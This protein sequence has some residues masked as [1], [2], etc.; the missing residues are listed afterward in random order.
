MKRK[1]FLLTLIIYSLVVSSCN[2]Q[3][4]DSPEP[5]E[6]TFNYARTNYVLKSGHTEEELE[7]A[8]WVNTNID[9]MIEAIE[10]PSIKDDFYTHVNY[11][12]ITNKSKGLFNKSSDQVISNLLYLFDP[13]E[14]DYSDRET[15]LYLYENIN[16][17]SK[18]DINNYLTSL[19]VDS[20]LLSKEAITLPSMPIKLLDGGSIDY[21]SFNYG[22]F[23]SL[24]LLGFYSF[25]ADYY[26]DYM[27]FK[28]AAIS[29]YTTLLT[30]MG[31]AQ[32]EIPQM[33]T[34]LLTDVG[35]YAYQVF[36][37]FHNAGSFTQK[38]VDSLQ[39]GLKLPLV[40]YGYALT[41]NIKCY[42][43]VPSAMSN[44]KYYINNLE[45]YI[46]MCIAFDYRFLLGKDNYN[47]ISAAIRS[48]QVFQDDFTFDEDDSEEEIA[49]KLVKGLVP[50]ILDKG[51]IQE[52]DDLELREQ[53]SNLID[54]VIAGYKTYVNQI[55]W[56]NDAG[57]NHFI[58]KLDNIR[59]F[60][61]YSD[62]VKAYPDFDYDYSSPTTKLEVMNDYFKYQMD[63]EIQ[64]LV[65]TEVSS[66]CYTV[67]AFYSP[68][69][70]SFTILF[71]LLACRDW[72]STSKE[73]LFARLSFVIGHEISHAFDPLRITY[74]KN[75]Q[76]KRTWGDQEIRERY[77]SRITKMVDFYNKI[78]VLNNVTAD[79][80][81]QKGEIFADFGAMSVMLNM[82]KSIENFNYDKFFKE[83]AQTWLNYID[84]DDLDYY[85]G[86]SHPLYFLRVNAVV[87]Q[88]EE[89]QNTYDIKLGDGMYV[90]A[91]ERVAPYNQ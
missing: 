58:S 6:D 20:F 51:Y 32:E 63:L 28:E 19:D 4:G 56:F 35:N 45:V 73:E 67:N 85:L 88:F 18:N 24:P 83:Y 60:S 30:V 21:L 47:N 86:D 69:S 49:A 15:A 13:V 76:D 78:H 34:G 44:M 54:E 9:G 70:N 46:K 31:Y 89:F 52:F 43:P 41:D 75:G 90:P 68:T 77:N 3:S 12:N 1:H 74:D 36:S 62:K 57:R 80:N 27:P 2:S 10:K 7:G 50:T 8:P 29:V 16:Q 17:G 37:N 14:S 53:V 71:G 48:L 84:Q 25:Y 40:D 5:P 23:I 91:K 38:T 79:G 39:D 33:V 42:N 82:A 61:L 26:E 72:I 55:T 65:E 64:G 87:S 11:E 66:A 59:K 81:N 22:Q